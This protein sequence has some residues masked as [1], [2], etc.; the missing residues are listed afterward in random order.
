M[1]GKGRLLMAT[2]ASAF[3]FDEATHAYSEDGMVRLSVTQVLKA[4][5]FFAWLDK[6][7]THTLERKRRL[8]ILTHR[9][10]Q[11]WDEGEDLEEYEIPAEVREDYLQGY[12]NFCDDCSFAPELI[13][14]RQIADVY[15]MRYG[16]TLDRRGLIHGK[17]HLVE[18]KCGA[19]ESPVWGVQLAGY[20][21]GLVSIQERQRD[22]RVAL[23]LGPQFN[24][25]YKLHPYDDPADYQIWMNSLANVIWKQNKGL[26]EFE[27]VPERLA[28]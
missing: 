7:P 27:A 20:D 10:T 11:L 26:Y 24:R 17:R 13:E 8:G 2:A 1:G 4:E 23:Q 14:H 16:M 22:P 19:S 3:T 5:G 15:G 6:V 28:A 9:A 25:G 18:V 12:F 21:L